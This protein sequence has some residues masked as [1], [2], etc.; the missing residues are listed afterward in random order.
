MSLPPCAGT[1]PLPTPPAPP[2][3][4]ASDDCEAGATI[5]G[6]D[7]YLPG[8]HIAT[9]Q[10]LLGTDPSGTGYSRTVELLEDPK[11]RSQALFGTIVIERGGNYFFNSY[12]SFYQRIII[13]NTTVTYY[14]GA[15]GAF[16]GGIVHPRNPI[17]L[18]AGVH[19]IQIEWTGPGV[20]LVYASVKINGPDYVGVSAR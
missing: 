18:S 5:R 8:G 4:T 15:Q 12:A 17:D 6:W 16:N 9:F 20:P 13:D 11:Y 2:P 14:Y 1:A 3:S 7:T 10:A 19:D